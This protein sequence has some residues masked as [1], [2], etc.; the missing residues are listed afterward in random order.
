MNTETKISD[1]PAEVVDLVRTWTQPTKPYRQFE[2][3]G[4]KNFIDV[5]CPECNKHFGIDAIDIHEKGE[6]SYL[7]PYSCPYCHIEFTLK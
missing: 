3:I 6:A 4:S 2:T 1:I 5:H 7:L